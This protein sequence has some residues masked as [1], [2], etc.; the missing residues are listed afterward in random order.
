MLSHN[1]PKENQSLQT[2]STIFHK[3]LKEDCYPF[4]ELCLSLFPGIS[5]AIEVLFKEI[6]QQINGSD[7]HF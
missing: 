2:A 6:I 7:P 1:N 5:L 4:G 3:L